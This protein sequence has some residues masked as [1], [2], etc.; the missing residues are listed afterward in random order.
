[1]TNIQSTKIEREYI[2]P[3]REKVMVA[4]RYK[5]TPK[6]VKTIKKFL[7]KHMRIYDR[8]LKKIKIDKYL[9]EYLWFRGIRHPPHKIKVKAIKD[10][11][12]GLVRVELAELPENLKFKKIRHEKREIKAS[13]KAGKKKSSKEPEIKEDKVTEQIEKEI[14]KN[15]NGIEDKKEEKEKV[16]S[17][18]EET[19]KI[20]K[21]LAKKEKHTA[22][23]ISPK[24]EKNK[25]VE[26]NKSSRGR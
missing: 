4:P 15:L 10:N 9:N 7:I 14:D 24:Q 20:E 17:V 3:L 12:S 26:Y 1:M 23:P 11:V 16:A 2:I 6:A 25:R 5:K 8:D 22:K 13:E 18:L 19:A 21:S